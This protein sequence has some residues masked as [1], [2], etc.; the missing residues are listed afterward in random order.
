MNISMRVRPFPVPDFV[1]VELPPGSG[2][3]GQKFPVLALAA[4][5]EESLEQLVMEFRSG[6]LA[7]FNEQ[8]KAPGKP[9]PRTPV[10]IT[11]STWSNP[12]P[13]LSGS[14]HD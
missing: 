1:F 10:A 14:L 12:G 5:T 8:R 7:K 2:A 3:D 11:P 4:L 6:L 9:T 13:N